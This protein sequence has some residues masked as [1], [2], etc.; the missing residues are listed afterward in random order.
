MEGWVHAR[1]VSAGCS[2]RGALVSTMTLRR[3]DCSGAFV[4]SSFNG[5]SNS[6]CYHTSTCSW[7]LSST[8]FLSLYCVI[9]TLPSPGDTATGSL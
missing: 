2:V 6:S 1:A 3:K 9:S 7:T 5:K 8:F 4:I